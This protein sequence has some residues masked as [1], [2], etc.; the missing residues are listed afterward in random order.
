MLNSGS[1]GRDA[2]L[3][4][5][6]PPAYS[7]ATATLAAIWVFGGYYV[8]A[9]VGFALTFLPNPISVLWPP[10]SILFA[11][12]LLVPAN[13]WWVVIAAALPAHFLAELQVGVPVSMV[14]SWFV[15]N[16]SEAL[17]GALSVRLLTRGP[18]R[19][20]RVR[21]VIVF[22]F[23]ASLA[24]FLSSFLDSALVVLNG[25]GKSTFWQLWTTRLFS[26]ITT[27]L[28]LVPMIVTWASGAAASLRS[29][30]WG[31]SVEGGVLFVG[32]LVIGALVFD[33]PIA[34][35]NSPAL[36]YVPLPLLLWA[37]LR[38]GPAGTSTS[39]MIVA[40]LAIFGAG[41]G[42]GALGMRSA[43]ENAAAVQLFLIF[44]APTMLILAAIVDERRRAEQ[45]LR[46]SEQRFSKAFRSSPNA[47][48]I[49]RRADG[50][51]L[52]VN[53]QWERLLGYSHHDAVG[54]DFHELNLC[55]GEDSRR[56]LD[57]HIEA[58]GKLPH[59]EINIRNKRGEILR[60]VIA[61][62]AVD[63]E[64]EQCFITNLRDVTDRRRAE[65]ALRES[66]E[67][68]RLALEAGHMGVWDWERRTNVVTWS[69]EHFEIM[70][71]PP[72]PPQA[73]YE[74]WAGRVHPD[75]LVSAAAAMDSAIARRTEYR[76]EYR[77]VRP[78]GT[79]RWVE[80]RGEPRFDESGEC[81]RVMG[82]ILDIS[83]RKQ[84]EE[85]SQKLFLASRLTVMGELT[86][87]IA[88]EIN[89]P[90]GA[91][92]T[93]AQTALR[94]LN[95][96]EPDLVEVRAALE[97]IATDNLRAGDI[98]RELRRF[99]RRQEPSLARIAVAELLEAVARFVSPEARN[100]GVEVCIDVADGLPEVL[101]DRVQIQQVLV[102]LLLNSFDALYT[103]P[104]GQRRVLLA[105]APAPANRI[106]ISVSDSGPGVPE[107]LRSSV[108]EPFVTTKPEGLGIGLAIAQT[109]VTAHGGRLA[110]SDA[111]EGG[112]VFAFSL[113]AAVQEVHGN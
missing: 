103:K 67:R 17:I 95:A 45:R 6:S 79:V 27:A 101:A 25:W 28:T 51:I 49:S 74:T 24:A 112:A 93:N 111:H 30:S 4:A 37:G 68:L 59:L 108:F 66:G 75:D 46:S 69:K 97:D 29:A 5:D 23:A 107:H 18:L 52:E 26:N 48:S 15:S 65:D 86:A 21:D 40:F 102:N 105:A 44:I 80:S 19:F 99:L 104:P 38:F 32:L 63:M 81:T 12:L 98:V 54:R 96:P 2:M 73:T 83:E 16:A 42:I 60:A 14:V 57:A 78:D 110:Y 22:I 61:V 87:S 82:L 89:Q 77:I 100:Q 7:R 33:A 94:L 70:G 90:L 1:I 11:A 47:M 8:G 9:K 71:L 92:L 85:T 76:N 88:H 31:R 109:I 56:R 34:T 43:A 91:S 50:R 39:L 3:T 72:V 62:E 55:V 10:N 36:L 41:N 64:G 13:M 53:D 106:A 20:G 35:T 113:A 58:Q 84:A